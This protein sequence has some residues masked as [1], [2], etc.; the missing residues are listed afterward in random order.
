MTL[1]STEVHCS[2]GV[3]NGSKISKRKEWKQY[4]QKII[5]S[6]MSC[7][8]MSGTRSLNRIINIWIVKKQEHQTIICRPS[9][10]LWGHGAWFPLGILCQKCKLELFI[11]ISL[12]WLNVYYFQSSMF[13]LLKSRWILAILMSLTENALELQL[14]IQFKVWN[15]ML[16]SNLKL[17]SKIFIM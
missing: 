9:V 8:R 7:N 17:L 12:A 4:T 14:W 3:F 1:F 15:I 5:K 2:M 13:V 6:V 11:I 10:G 16:N